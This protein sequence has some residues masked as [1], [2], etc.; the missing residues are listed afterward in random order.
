MLLT[1]NL[2]IK[3]KVFKP[4]E[5]TFEAFEYYSIEIAFLKIVKDNTQTTTFGSLFQ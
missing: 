4:S 1:Y 5:L 2:R 3:N